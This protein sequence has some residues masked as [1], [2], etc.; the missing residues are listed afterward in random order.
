[1]H[2]GYQR[3]LQAI[4]LALGGRPGA[5]LVDSLACAVSRMTLLRLIRALPL[6][7]L[8]DVPVVGVSMTSRYGA[9]ADVPPCSSTLPYSNGPSEGAVT[10]TKLLK[11]QMYGRANLDLL[12][13]LLLSG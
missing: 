8:G 7:E 4:A 2:S 9:V 5:R 12:R 10:K 3:R 13:R 11:R 1:V 6:R